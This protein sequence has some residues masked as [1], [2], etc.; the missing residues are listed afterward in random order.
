MATHE[1]R[2]RSLELVKLLGLGHGHQPEGLSE[3]PGVKTRLGCRNRPLR[4]A[5][6]ILGQLDCPAEKRGSGGDAAA[7]LRTARRAFELGSDLLV[8]STR[9]ASAVPRPAVRVLLRI[10]GIGQGTMHAAPIAP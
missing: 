7:G 4:S 2:A 1:I 9:G 3:G 10:G 5:R 8:G 6:R